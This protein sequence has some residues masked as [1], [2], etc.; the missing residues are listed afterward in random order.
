MNTTEIYLNGK[1]VDKETL[2]KR[3]DAI[4]KNTSVTTKKFYSAPLTE[5]EK[6]EQRRDAENTARFFE[7]MSDQR[8]D[9]EKRH[10]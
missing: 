3:K 10:G 9:L 2:K 5:K 7:R 8:E 6:E 1:L 4:L